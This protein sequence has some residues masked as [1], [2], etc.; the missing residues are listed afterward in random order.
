VNVKRRLF[1]HLAA[2]EP[3][4]RQESLHAAHRG[5]ADEPDAADL[6]AGSE[7]GEQVG[8]GLGLG[9]ARVV[10]R[11]DE[12]GALPAGLRVRL[13]VPQQDERGRVDRTHGEVREHAVVV[14]VAD[15]A[16]GA[17]R[18]YPGDFVD[19][20]VGHGA[21]VD[22]QHA[23]RPVVH[24]LGAAAHVV[25]DGDKAAAQGQPGAAFFE[26]L[27]DG[28]DR[29]RL[30]GLR[31]ALGQRPVIVFAAVHKQDFR[32]AAGARPPGDAAGRLDQLVLLGGRSMVCHR[33]DVLGSYP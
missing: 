24:S 12:V 16:D 13:G 30:A 26:H 27:A 1:P 17:A 22:R 11:A 20:G 28:G 33:G 31:L 9:P 19:L 18:G 25:P 10:K 3:G 8:E 23:G 15:P 2:G 5:R 14:G 4:E 32:L 6:G 7:A 21:V 29:Q